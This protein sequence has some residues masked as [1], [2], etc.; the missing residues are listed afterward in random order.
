MPHSHPLALRS[1]DRRAASTDPSS[2]FFHFTPD[3]G[4]RPVR[5]IHI[6]TP[7]DVSTFFKEVAMKKV[8]VEPTLSSQSNDAYNTPVSV[9][10]QMRKIEL[11]PSLSAQSND[12]YNTPT[13]APLK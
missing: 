5:L 12:A 4:N 2:D 8:N 13:T 9:P 11:E 10:A 1:I 7:A 6:C 3:L